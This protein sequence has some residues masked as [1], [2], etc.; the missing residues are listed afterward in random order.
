VQWVA[1][2]EQ[3]QQVLL[4]DS[5]LL[6][7]CLSTLYVHHRGVGCLPDGSG[8]L[9]VLEA[10]PA[11]RLAPL[12]VQHFA[13]NTRSVVQ[14]ALQALYWLSLKQHAQEVVTQNVQRTAQRA[15]QMEELEQL[16]LGLQ[17]AAVELAQLQVARLPQ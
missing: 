1:D 11:S 16:T 14:G 8:V 2:L 15:A 5:E 10:L 7:R 9:V 3:T 17:Q 12:L 13:S 6:A 4:G